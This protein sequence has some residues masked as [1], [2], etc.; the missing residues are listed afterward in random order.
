MSTSRLS[1]CIVLVFSILLSTGYLF[2]QLGDPGEKQLERNTQDV[3]RA[4][5]TVLLS[6]GV[7]GDV[8][9]A[10]GKVTIEHSV[11]EDVIAAGGFVTITADVNDD[12]R[13]AGGLVT[14]SGDV[15]DDVVAAAYSISL[16]SGSTVG[17]DAWL[18]GGTVTVA[19]NV[20]QGL[21]VNG[22]QV[23]LSGTYGGDVEVRADSFEIEPGAVIRGNLTYWAANEAVI[24]DG[25]VVEGEVT[26]QEFRLED[27]ET[28]GEAFLDSLKFYLSLAICAVLIFMVYPHGLV[29]VVE[30]LNES[31]F[32]SLGIGLVVL[33]MAPL[34]AIL[35]LFTV[36]GIPL[37]L[38]ALTVYLATLVAG[39]LMGLIWI[40]DAG[41]HLLG[42]EP[43]KTKWTRTG[44]IFA[45]AAVLMLIGFIPYVGGWIFFAVL[46]L[47]I[48]SMTQ[49][50][51]RL[52]TT[53]P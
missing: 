45:A 10:G 33:V 27:P 35:L 52:Y 7:D 39:L 1:F 22:E 25:A 32:Q 47:G 48:G 28:W 36:I 19:G 12:V 26:R 37:G 21:N 30:R 23:T 24:S 49:Y 3:Y 11:S 53:Q 51:Y 13:T 4:G 44:S 42:Q 20:N 16:D 43:D 9:V 18:S 2:A 50:F 29:K 46:L 40:G 5:G 8:V 38:I 14:I 34:T 6:D 15:G 41:F 17:G 31:P